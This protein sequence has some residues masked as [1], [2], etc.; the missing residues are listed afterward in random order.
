MK[1]KKIDKAIGVASDLIEYDKLY[2]N[3]ILSLLGRTVIVENMDLGV[4]LAKENNYSFKIV[5]LQGDIIN[6]S[7]AISGGSVP[8]RTTSILGRKR[9]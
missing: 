5:T 2:E 6:P 3:I 1:K 7:G 4:E 9:N 8:K